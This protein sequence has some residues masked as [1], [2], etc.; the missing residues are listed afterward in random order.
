MGDNKCVGGV[1]KKDSYKCQKGDGFEILYDKVLREGWVTRFLSNGRALRVATA[2]VYE[3]VGNS[4]VLDGTYP[5]MKGVKKEFGEYCVLEYKGKH[6]FVD[7]PNNSDYTLA[8]N[9]DIGKV[10]EF[11]KFSEDD[12]R[13]RR[14]LDNKYYCKVRVPKM[15]AKEIE[16]EATKEVR[17]VWVQEI[18][19]GKPVFEDKEEV[20]SE[21]KGVT[22]E[23]RDAI[24]RGNEYEEKQKDFRKKKHGFLEKYGQLVLPVATLAICLIMIVVTV[25][26]VTN[27]VSETTNEVKALRESN[28]PWY[29]NDEILDDVA[30]KVGKL[31]DE[32]NA[33]PTK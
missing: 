21:P 13:I 30:D 22:Q 23:G 19:D 24:R 9:K 26:R 7:V 12:F 28:T 33:P 6:Y 8:N 1:S 2:I 31:A 10:I 15:V 11:V 32:R 18:K 29:A 20:Y 4:E 3:R 27:M 17:K 25:D 14:R 5:L 16:D